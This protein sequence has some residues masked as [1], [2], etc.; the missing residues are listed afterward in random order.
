[1][2]GN[3]LFLILILGFGGSFQNGYHATGLSSPS[4][5]IQSFMNSS[6]YDRYE[7]PPSPHTLTLMWSAVVS[8]YA[9][10]GL[11]GSI[12]VKFM[13]ELLG[14]KKAII[15][16]SFIA[17][18]A[19]VIMVTSKYANSFEMIIVASEILGR[20]ELWNVVICVSDCFSLVQI[21]LLPFFPEAP[22]YLLIEKNDHEASK[23]ALQ[24]LWGPG[25]YK[26]EIE[27]MVAE[28]AAIEMARPKSLLE[29]FRDKSVRWQIITLFIIGTCI[30]FSGMS[31]ISVFSFDI[32]LEAGIPPEKIHYVTLGLGASEILT[33]IFCGFLIECT[34]RRPCCGE[35]LVPCALV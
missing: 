10:G 5:Y 9:V 28:Q 14:I 22:R 32:F 13:K 7:E 3:V 2:R 30:Q 20:E 21:L 18:V 19:V 6:W 31:A 8:M 34:E 35:V 26:E 25:E 17:V 4:P 24:S 29:L 15:C 23:K 1:T 11:L 27:E 12:C 33:Y 16:N